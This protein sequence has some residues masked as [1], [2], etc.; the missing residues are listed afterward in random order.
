MTKLMLKPFELDKVPSNTPRDQ[1][2]NI[3]FNIIARDNEIRY[4]DIS[5]SNQLALGVGHLCKALQIRGSGD[6]IFAYEK[7]YKNRS[8][9]NN[10]ALERFNR[11][12]RNCTEAISVLR[13]IVKIL[14]TA[15]I[16]QLDDLIEDAIP[17]LSF[18]Y[19]LSLTIYALVL[20]KETL[21]KFLLG[22]NSHR[23]ALRPA[24]TSGVYFVS[25]QVNNEATK[26]VYEK[27]TMFLPGNYAHYRDC[28]P[29]LQLMSTRGRGF[30]EHLEIQTRDRPVLEGNIP[31]I[32]KSKEETFYLL[33]YSYLQT[34]KPEQCDNVTTA[35][36]ASKRKD[37]Y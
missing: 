26:A 7:A 36:T 14:E 21:L 16:A 28:L 1:Y 6:V 9:I 19:E 3:D 13:M 25:S 31:V 5:H 37:V 15:L 35:P 30:I 23:R 32:S 17:F 11:R 2:G 10:E 22:M 4:G 34:Q 18:P 33:K 27:S 24:V 20:I 29:A 8:R 12:A